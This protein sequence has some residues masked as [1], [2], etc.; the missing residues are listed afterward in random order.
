MRATSRSQAHVTSS[1]NSDVI[2]HGIR[3]QA[4]AQYLPDHSDPDER[5]FVF[6]YRIV[7]FNEGE[8]RAQL[9]TRHWIIVDANG[10]RRDV[11]GPGV[12][13]E[14]PDLGP[15]ESF[16]YLSSCPL[17]TSWGTM[18]GSY[19]FERPDGEEFSVAIGRFFLVPGATSMQEA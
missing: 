9:K 6:V 11:D 4:A 7:I 2:T 5:N 14:Y 10:K 12:V 18:Q 19:V 3:I 1:P 15:S 16:E 17:T 8:E 13:G